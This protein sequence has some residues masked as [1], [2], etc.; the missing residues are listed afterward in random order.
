[1][2]VWPFCIY[3]VFLYCPSWPRVD[4]LFQCKFIPSFH[5]FLICKFLC[6]HD[7]NG[8]ATKIY[9]FSPE[10]ILHKIFYRSI[11]KK[12]GLYRLKRNKFKK[13]KWNNQIIAIRMDEWHHQQ[14]AILMTTT[15]KSKWW[16]PDLFIAYL[17]CSLALKTWLLTGMELCSLQLRSLL[18]TIP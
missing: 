2:S 10:H 4:K 17:H 11:W 8:S 7:K 5:T 9:N 6:H 14:L 13:R 12:K 1:M 3:L 15:M 18:Y 16:I